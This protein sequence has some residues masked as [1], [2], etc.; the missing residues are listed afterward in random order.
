MQKWEYQEIRIHRVYRRNHLG[1]GGQDGA[2]VEAWNPLVNLPKLGDDG[3]EMVSVVPISTRAG[4]YWA[5]VTDDL[6]F[7]FK[8]P[9]PNS[10]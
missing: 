3:W 6:I 5:G 4:E 8:R 9:K 1:L 2:T 7:Y 10:A